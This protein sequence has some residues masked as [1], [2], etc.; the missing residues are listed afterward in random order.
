MN[1]IRASIQKS[2][3]ASGSGNTEAAAGGSK[4][5]DT[6]RQEEMI[7]VAAYF[8]AEQR[9]FVPGSELDDWLQAEAE[10]KARSIPDT[11]KSR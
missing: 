8:R 3:K 4:S 11:D 10:Y 1:I 6:S 2:R 5:V 9:D 7:A